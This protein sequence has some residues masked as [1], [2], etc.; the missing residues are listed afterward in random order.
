MHRIFNFSMLDYAEGKKKQSRDLC[1][2]LGYWGDIVVS[3][4]YTF[5]LLV[6]DLNEKEKFYKLQNENYYYYNEKISEYFVEKMIRE[7]NE[8]KVILDRIK[9]QVYL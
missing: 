8:C 6:D 3:P 9:I 4:F 2:V 7:M 1:D 5:G